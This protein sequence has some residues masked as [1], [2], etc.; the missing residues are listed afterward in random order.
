[1]WNFGDG[2]LATTQNPSHSYAAAGTYNVM[3]TATNAGGSSSATKP[4]TVP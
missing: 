3:L 2:T 4:V 1:V